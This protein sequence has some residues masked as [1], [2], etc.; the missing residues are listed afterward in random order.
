MTFIRIYRFHRRGGLPVRHALA[1]AIE[2][3]TRNLS[4]KP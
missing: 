4:F 1:R 2:S 3:I